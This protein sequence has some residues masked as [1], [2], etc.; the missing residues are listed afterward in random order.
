MTR[1]YWAI[2]FEDQDVQPQLFTDEKAAR[3]TFDQY[4]LKWACHLFV[5]V[6]A[7]ASVVKEG[8]TT[9]P[10]TKEGK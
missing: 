4:S 5:Q 10:D 9:A 3:E 7:A 8:L 6:D 2:I 1:P